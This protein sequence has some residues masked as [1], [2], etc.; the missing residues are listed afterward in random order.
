MTVE[1]KRRQLTVNLGEFHDAFLELAAK[2]AVKPATLAAAI[3]KQSVSDEIQN[4]DK[5]IA[6]LITPNNSKAVHQ[7]L[8]LREDE[9]KVLDEYSSI[10]GQTR[11]QA[12]VGLVRA[13]TVNEPQFTIGE[14]ESLEKSNYELHKIGVNLN[15]IAHKT[16]MLDLE[17]FKIRKLKSLCNL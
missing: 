12:L 7:H 6:L 13:I 4:G 1:K 14:I 5:K 2:Y 9:L 16:N 3:L 11:H 10:M 15:Q 8:R 17:K